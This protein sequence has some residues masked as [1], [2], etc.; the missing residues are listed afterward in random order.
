MAG[1]TGLEP[2]AS[3]LTVQCANQA[4]PRARMP[5]ESVPRAAEGAGEPR[6]ERELAAVF[7]LRQLDARDAQ[8][9]LLREHRQHRGHCAF[10]ESELASDL[11]RRH[12][13]V[14]LQAGLHLVVDL[15]PPTVHIQ[16]PCS[17]FRTPGEM[18]TVTNG[19]RGGNP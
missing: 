1:S 9:A 5:S 6:S 11:R 10:R 12:R 7:A 14:A 15:V 3:G 16:L 4:A 2:A 18:V 8:L 13:A 19:V 17:A